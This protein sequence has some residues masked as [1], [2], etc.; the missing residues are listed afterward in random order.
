MSLSPSS[1]SNSEPTHAKRKRAM[2]YTSNAG[3]DSQYALG[4]M[5]PQAHPPNGQ[6]SAHLA[7]SSTQAPHPGAAPVDS[8]RISAQIPKRG[9][10]AC[11]ACRKGK[12]RCEGEMSGTQCVFEKPEKKNQSNGPNNGSAERVSRLEG[13]YLM[14]QSQMIG[15]Q[16]SLDRILSAIQSQAG[17]PYQQNGAI[18][19]TPQSASTY[20]A[21]SESPRADVSF[22]SQP[23]V[24]SSS[25]EGYYDEDRSPP[26]KKWPALPGFAP[27]PHKFATYGI[28]P[29][30]A[31]SSDDESEDTLPRSALNAPIEALQGLANAAVEAAAGPSLSPRRDAYNRVK[32]RKRV[33]PTPRNAF[34]NVLDKGLVREEEAR[35]LYHMYD[36]DFDPRR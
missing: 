9:A 10:R 35:E 29:S 11:T 36:T 15:M 33:E 21:M 1:N 32:K 13:Q 27:P 24:P 17:Q 16:S 34:P 12:N 25:R 6:Y 30:T 8:T 7:T 4:S 5:H 22:T 18:P 28:V 20:P 23:V 2:S 14:M 26:R 19:P 31:P 3:S